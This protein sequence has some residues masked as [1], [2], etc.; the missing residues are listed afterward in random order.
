MQTRPIL[1]FLTALILFTILT[2]S[3][4][5]SARLISNL[6]DKRFN[7]RQTDTPADELSDYNPE[8][9]TFSPDCTPPDIT[10][11]IVNVSC[12][13]GADAS[14]DIT[15]SG[16]TPPYIFTW[17]DG[18][19]S[20][21]VPGQEDQNGLT[22]G[23]YLLTVTDNLSCTRDTTFTVLEPGSISIT[24]ESAVDA[25]CN[26][27]TTGSVT[28]TATGGTGAL[29][30]TLNPGGISNGSGLFSNLAAN[31]YTVSVTDAN[32]CGPV[33]S[34]N[35]TVGEPP[36]ITITSEAK[37]DITC[38]GNNNG[39]ITIVASGGTGQLTY[40]LNPGS[41]TNNTGFFS[42]LA[43]GAYTI[44][45]SDANSCG[46]VASNAILI[47]DPPII[48]ISSETFTNITCNGA[49]DGT[50]TIT[51]TGG[52]NPLKYT[53]N[54]GNTINNTG[55]FT[56][57]SANTYTVTVSDVN[58]CVPA[59]SSNL[60]ITEP[61]PISITS[62]K[63][64]N[65]TCNGS[66][67]GEVT[68]TAIGGT[69]LLTYTLNPGGISNTTGTFQ[70]L[71]A[72]TYTVSVTDGNSCGPVLS[73][74]LIVNEP[75]AIIIDNT[76]ITDASCNGAGNGS[77]T[78][79]ASGGTGSVLIYT[80]SPGAITNGTGI[81]NGLIAGNYTVSVTD[82]NFCGPVVTGNLIVGEPTPITITSETSTNISCHGAND[83]IV[84]VTASGGTGV[85]TY[86]LNPG[87]ISNTS[88]VFTG[89]GPN[90][91]T[92]SVSDVNSCG[93]VTSGN[94]FV[95]EPPTIIITSEK[96]TDI[97]CNGAGDGTVTVTAI[98][99]SGNL[100]YT[101]NPGGVSNTT[102]TFTNLIANTYTVSITDDN[103][104]GPVISN[105]FNVTEPPPILINSELVTDVTCFGG[106]NGAVSVSASGGTGILVYTLNPIGSVNGTG[107]FSGLSA[108]T[109]TVSVT[110]LSGCG[111][112]I[113][114][115]LIVGQPAPIVISGEA[116][117]NISCNGANDGTITIGASGGT[118]VL[119][120]TLNP[121]G[122]SNSTGVFSG[123]SPNNYT[124]S[125]TDLNSC[126]PVISSNISITEPPVLT[127]TSESSTNITCNGANDG[128]ISVV[129]SGGTPPY[130]YSVDGGTSYLSNG[131][132]FTG[133]A[134]GN[135]NISVRDANACTTAGSSF[136]LTE[137]AALTISGVV[138]NVS[139]NGGND[140]AINIT[141][142]GG[143]LPY[144]YSWSH[145][146]TTEDV[147]GLTAGSYS[148]TV[149]DANGCSENAAFS[150][151]EPTAISI[152]GSVSHISCN[153]AADGSIDVTTSGGTA[154]YSFA[155]S[156]GPS[157]E[158][159][160]GLNPGSYILTVTDANSC[161]ANASFT[162]TEPSVLVITGNVSDVSCNGGAN[163][164][165]DLTTSGGT[166]PYSFAWS[167]GPTTEDVSGLAAGSYSVI[168]TDA[169]LC[170][171]N[172]SF[173]VNEPLDI[174]IT[175]TSTN[176]SCNGSNDGSILITASQGTPP[177]QYSVDGGATYLTNGGNFTGL[178][179]GNYDIAVRDAAACVKFG[180]TIT[181]TEPAAINISGTVTNVS[182]NGGNDGAINITVNGGV[183][184]YSFSWSNG[185][186]SEDLSGL[187]AGTYT[188][189]V[190]DAN[191]CTSN[192]SFTVTEPSVLVVS[193]IVSDVSCN[194]ST[195][196][197][198]DITVSGGTAPYSYLWSHGPISEDISGLAAGSYSVTVTDANA[199]STIA[200][201]N[202]TEP[203]DLTVSATS[204]NISCNGLNDGSIIITASQG[205]PPY[206]YSID[207]GVTYL[208][209]GG[210][211]TGLPQGNYDIAVRDAAACV[212]FGATVII[213]EPS[214]LVVSGI[215]TDVSC[216]G[217]NDGAVNITISG[218]TLPYTYSWSNGSVS[219][220]ISGL[221]SGSYTVTVTD[222]NG[223]SEIVSF[224]ITEPAAIS[225]SSIVTDVSCNGNADGAIDI[226]VSGGT[227]PYSYAWSHGPT[228]EDLTGLTAGTYNL[229]VT[230]ASGCT[231][232]ASFTVSEPLTITINSTVSNVSCNGGNDGAINLTVSGGTSPYTYVWSHGPV[233]KDVS[234]LT[235][236]SYT[237]TVTDANSC[238]ELASFNITEPL[239]LTISATST[240]ISCNGL[241]N[242]SVT[243]SASQGTP[244]YEY[245]IDGGVTYLAN[246]GSFTGLSQGNY[247]I[248]VR[249]AAACVKFD[250]TITITEPAALDISGIITDV[251]CNG[252]NDGAVSV[253]VS[254]G[255][256]P[257]SY[258]WSNGETTKDISNLA[259]GNYTLTVV[260]AN[261]CPSSPV[262]I[263]SEPLAISISVSSDNISCNG[264]TDGAISITASQGTTPY[265]YSIDGGV[266][267]LAN[268]G[269][270]PWLSQGNY[271]IAVRDASGCIQFGSTVIITEPQAITLSASITDVS[272]A[273]GNDGIID[274]A[275]SGGTAPFSYAWSNGA[276]TED[277]S[278]LS[279]GDYSVT[280]TD[281]N[282]CTAN[283]S[284][285]VK[286]PDVNITITEVITNVSCNG[287]NDGA[288]EITVTGGIEPYT[289]AWST[290][291]GSGLV[292]GVK[293]QSGLSG[294]S[295]DVLVTD[296]AGNTAN[297]SYLV[298]EPVAITYTETITDI[299]CFGENSGAI[300][301]TG[302][303]GNPPFKY[304]LN[305][306]AYQSSGSFT[307]LAA[308]NYIITIRDN[309]GCTTDADLSVSQP[310]TALTGDITSQTDVSCDGSTNGSVSV[311]G[312]GGVSPYEYSMN[313]GAYQSSGSYTDLAA[314]NYTVT[315]RDANTCTFDVAV[316]INVGSSDLDISI[317]DQ[318]DVLCYGDETGSVSVTGTGGVSPYEYSIDGTD[319]QSSGIF[320]GLTAK[321]YTITVKDAN[322]CSSSIDVSISEPSPIVTNPKV[323]HASCP[324]TNDGSIEL[325][326]EGGTTPYSFRWS[327][328]ETTEDLENISN[329]T[330]SVEI[331]DG[332]SCI[333]NT[334]I[335]VRAVGDNCLEIP[336]AFIPNGDGYNDTWKIR[337][338]DY[339]PNASVEIFTRWGQMVYSSKD[340]YNNP[341]DGRF[342]GKDMPMDAYYYVI[343]LKNGKK[344]LTGTVTIMR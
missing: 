149:T 280:V 146:P 125:I 169:N 320:T 53:L 99:G 66:A 63:V 52:T 144:T 6:S 24:S 153:G 128:T 48:T 205:T 95:T 302:S 342:K 318:N 221:T 274:L 295:Y 9:N 332:N 116:S 293:D 171:T 324:G 179:Q 41:I 35:L 16:G 27:T 129:A 139:C 114:N 255:M 45:V 90:T 329:G 57:L 105:S 288:I 317:T 156:H 108:G 86:T 290:S 282:G 141:V 145:G 15:V 3:A 218:G 253:S 230:D 43:G 68:V 188:V 10:A 23:T 120:Y 240:N 62:E 18:T 13:G 242:G 142:N 89:L 319:F 289:Y 327:N 39:T 330:Y 187:P 247:D 34:N 241:N 339:F 32:S 28:V 219:E 217:G 158:D 220:D 191:S 246:G 40:T 213:T 79:S 192:T 267:W 174:I 197:S 4:G 143:T 152:T 195:D 199:C 291:D 56:N 296:N 82:I 303:D 331:T 202:V 294:G 328:S 136:T 173:T 343:D 234:G 214:A 94:L 138:T 22:A 60:N 17:T 315:V 273:G 340:G 123:L 104:C 259:A 33:I 210:N 311:E 124:V 73:N 233:L 5:Y 49:N 186:I 262:F 263:V 160:S 341:W 229:T 176:I 92:V 11:A 206:Q 309:S 270:F 227:G 223:C 208:A 7:P 44:Q 162:V 159:V 178:A 118:G 212:K 26:G 326:T 292:P 215:V 69:S 281:I 70:N 110:D 76:T 185:S 74:P 19:G 211:F 161:T 203:L 264:L 269:S 21:S 251:S 84:T 168:V 322:L 284:Y 130:M 117:T 306:G 266:S 250:A 134:P 106:S 113:S 55:V 335:E 224:N 170:T 248:A 207:G 305:G 245:S 181:I 271:D 177:Y 190:T 81:F 325:N 209:N 314:G 257:Y 36:A 88:G 256:P 276:T 111:P 91:Y 75:P 254:G 244:P 333:Y 107:L 147:S 103:S 196:G 14:I 97:S 78:V 194:G 184:P 279:A 182:C 201:F 304:S 87:G 287:S 12:N 148:V 119:T 8:L 231:N 300:E 308:G 313:G 249:D 278:G 310:A 164:S 133:L 1:K 225:V 72:N 109:Y 316:T 204:S 137:P 154:P 163:G 277:I 166:A 323:V 200:S 59:L 140:G 132:N 65:I 232:N 54:P 180:A 25:S 100:I 175:T 167:H 20:G 96:Y 243:I 338:I 67:N 216:N 193:G 285:Q 238:S 258:S 126:G 37:T 235:A 312:S 297:G 150:V 344:P 226:T 307:N 83:G 64:T 272:V 42:G 85:L 58:G 151:T 198:I 115:N 334:T 286:E 268:G 93:P 102:G 80:L 2:G 222:A 29:I 298:T 121:G 31:T 30:Y 237:V 50:I 336:N 265:E 135:Y 283:D 122:I 38:N 239:D 172:A 46:P 299:S 301:I 236:G 189:T 261:G 127:I 71:T 61:I 260:D 155:W 51:A 47:V 101:L 157:S 252:G 183:S 98:G 337:N 165:I 228:S 131:G 112:V 275:V 77:I 321:L